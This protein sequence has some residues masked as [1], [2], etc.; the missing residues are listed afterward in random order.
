MDE[1][2]GNGRDSMTGRMLPGNRLS[3]GNRGANPTVRR[4]NELRRVLTDAASDDDIRDVYRS[5]LVAAKGGD[6][7][8]ARLLLDHLVGRPKESVE[9]T[10]GDG[11]AIGLASIAA[12]VM[13]AIGDD[14]SARVRVAT[15]FAR[16]GGNG[17]GVV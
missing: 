9:I 17:G 3:V 7:A 13:E 16:L 10:A 4:M 2:N 5:L 11:Q 12:V 15:A 14:E 8:A 1:A 6:V